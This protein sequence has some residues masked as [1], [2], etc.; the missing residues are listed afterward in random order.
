D[1][2]A[3]TPGYIWELGHHYPDPERA[4]DRAYLD[5]HGIGA[6]VVTGPV[7][8][9]AVND[10][11]LDLRRDGTFRVFLVRDPTTMVT[12]AGSNAG[13]T[14][15]SP[16]TIVASETGT[17]GEATIRLNWFPRWRTSVN[18]EAGP[19]TRRDDGSMQVPIPGGPV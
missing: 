9:W 8:D 15:V 13:E 2:H 6:V 3:G 1:D 5:Q 10:P 11:G 18:G 7:A 16:N 19:V 17:A 4:L 14:V 12:F